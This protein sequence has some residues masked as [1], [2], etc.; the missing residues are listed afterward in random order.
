VAFNF[1]TMKKISSIIK[2]LF[3]NKDNTSTS[4][5]PTEL[6]WTRKRVMGT[7]QE[8]GLPGDYDS[9]WRLKNPKPF[10]ENGARIYVDCNHPEYASPETTNPLDAMMWDK[11][12]EYIIPKNLE[13]LKAEEL[14]LFKNNIDSHENSYGSHESY[15]MERSNVDQSRFYNSMLGFLVTRIIF[16]GSGSINNQGEY[17]ISQKARSINC[18]IS[19]MTTYSEK[20]IVNTRDVHLSNPKYYR[21]HVVSGDANLSETPIFLKMG[22]MALIL[23]LYEDRKLKNISIKNPLE[24]LHR[25]SR[26]TDL[27]IRIDTD[28]GRF[29]AIEI[30]KFYHEQADREY[31]GRDSMT[32]DILNRWRNTL[33]SLEEEP[34]ELSRQLDW[35]IK[36]NLIDS[37]IKKTNKRLEEPEVRNID[38]QY[39]ELGGGLFYML[40]DNG[41]V[42][43]IASDI[44]I[45][46][47]IENPPEDTRAW[48][49]GRLISSK[50][51][52]SIWWNK[53]TLKDETTIELPDPYG[54]T[55]EDNTL[56]NIL[57]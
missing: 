18:N 48:A 17:E 43:R 27:K 49:R 54:E 2:K 30:Q 3:Q 42:D 23:D 20:P 12:G 34:L 15:C 40:E 22:T 14:R 29:T 56:E 13:R 26:D 16:A 39:H 10:I 19:S 52:K 8:Y 55:K 53:I 7:E 36:R 6:L 1:I 57:N 46:Y 45:A 21:F 32:D 44:D 28:K 11:A 25:I 47:A 4:K 51:V 50:K 38:L 33:N 5:A 35:I 41:Y 9:H 24:S 31:R 37:Y